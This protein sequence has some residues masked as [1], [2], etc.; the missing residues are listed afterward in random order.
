MASGNGPSNPARVQTL[1][2]GD[3]DELPT[4]VPS[5]PN[6]NLPNDT[7]AQAGG[8]GNTE[9]HVVVPVHWRGARTWSGQQAK[10]L[11]A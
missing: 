11:C 8:D 7:L 4:L 9:Y 5:L 1:D 2:F 10:R 3:A 6:T